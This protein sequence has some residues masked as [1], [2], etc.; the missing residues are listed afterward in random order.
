[1]QGLRGDDD[2][3]FFTLPTDLRYFNTVAE[4]PQQVPNNWSGALQLMGGTDEGEKEIGSRLLASGAVQR[5]RRGLVIELPSR[6]GEPDTRMTLQQL[7]DYAKEELSKVPAYDF[8]NFNCRHLAMTLANGVLKHQ[9][10][11]DLKRR[12]F[13]RRYHLK[14]KGLTKMTIQNR[15]RSKLKQLRKQ[16]AVSTQQLHE[17]QGDNLDTGATDALLR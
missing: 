15:L 16:R 6:E 12:E 14:Q 3:A 4:S 13:T 17:P 11:P 10:L 1:M 8:Y 2:D 5:L 9:A 7:A